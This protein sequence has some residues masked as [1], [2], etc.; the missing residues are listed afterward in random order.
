[1]AEEFLLIR[2]VT[3]VTKQ[4]YPVFVNRNSSNAGTSSGKGNYCKLRSSENLMKQRE[5]LDRV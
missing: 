1:M 5:A 4:G 2:L 3:S